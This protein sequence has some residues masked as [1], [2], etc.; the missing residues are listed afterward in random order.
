MAAKKFTKL[1]RDTAKIEALNM[2]L[3]GQRIPQIAAHFQLSYNSAKDLYQ[4]AL[5]DMRPHADF[6]KYR[7]TQL[8]EL[9]KARHKIIQTLTAGD[10]KATGLK[11]LCIALVTI[12]QQEGKLVGLDKAPYGYEDALARVAKMS[13][14]ELD[15]AWRQFVPELTS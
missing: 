4:D 15:A 2:V 12:Q 10:Y 7:A 13:D 5:D 6:D 8:A 9:K 1:E 14:S 3:E 11:D